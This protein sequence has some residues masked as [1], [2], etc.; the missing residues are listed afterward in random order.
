[1]TKL[2]VYSLGF[3]VSFAIQVS[4]GADTVPNELQQPGTQPSE[5]ANLISPDTCDNCHGGFNASVEPDYLWR[6]SMMSQAGRDPVFWATMAIAEQN[7]DGAGDLCIRCHSPAGWLAGKSTPTDGSALTK[8]D[9]EGVECD[10][11]HKL[12]NP[13]DSEHLGFMIKPFV[14]NEEIAPGE[15]EGYYGSGM[16]S[17][18][19]GSGSRSQRGGHGMSMMWVDSIPWPRLVGARRTAAV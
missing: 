5:I 14:A 9:S 12:T 4:Y 1:M 2:I 13:D 8:R 16:S 10:Y 18:W 11:C 17:M 7:F 3:L 19:S 6:G 15:I